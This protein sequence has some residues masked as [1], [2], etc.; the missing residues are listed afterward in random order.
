MFEED[1]EFRAEYS[2]CLKDVL[3]SLEKANDEA[4]YIGDIV[5]A[6][7][8]EEMSEIITSMLGREEEEDD[9]EVRND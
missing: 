4:Y 1:S 7:T 5:G 8:L 3:I 6:L 2:L 9:E